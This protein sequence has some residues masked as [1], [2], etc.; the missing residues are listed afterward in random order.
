MGIATVERKNSSLYIPILAAGRNVPEKFLFPAKKF[1]TC[2]Q[3]G[4]GRENIF[5]SVLINLIQTV[6]LI[7]LANDRN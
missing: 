4:M 1:V 5:T 7:A 3:T 2:G 6:I